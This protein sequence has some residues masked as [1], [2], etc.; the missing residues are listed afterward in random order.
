MDL[1]N[2]RPIWEDY[3]VAGK[4]RAQIA[5]HVRPLDEAELR[6]GA[7]TESELAVGVTVRHTA[8]F[9]GATELGKGRL[10]AGVGVVRSRDE[11][12]T[13]L[14]ELLAIARREAC[15]LIDGWAAEAAGDYRALLPAERL[16]ES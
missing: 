4:L 12:E 7:A 16:P 9:R 13:K 6:L 8:D 2:F 3:S 15:G 14:E 5:A 11:L 1:K 10:P